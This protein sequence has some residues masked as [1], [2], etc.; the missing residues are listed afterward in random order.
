MQNWKLWPVAGCDCSCCCACRRATLGNVIMK[1]DRF[2]IM[3][4]SFMILLLPE[5]GRR[6]ES[7]E[8]GRRWTQLL[9]KSVFCFVSQT[10]RPSVDVAFT[11][12]I[13][14][15]SKHTSRYTCAV[16]RKCLKKKKTLN[17]STFKPLMCDY[18]HFKLVFN[19]CFKPNRQQNFSAFAVMRKRMIIDEP[20]QCAKGS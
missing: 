7:K 19:V 8:N 5:S 14:Y 3:H 12:K 15:L 11:L 18:S 20:T 17:K 16:I 6:E 10:L 2:N 1:C 13:A 4:Y 9:G